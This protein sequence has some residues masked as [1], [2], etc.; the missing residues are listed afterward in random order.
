[1][2]PKRNGV[3]IPSKNVE[4]YFGTEKAIEL[5]I[6]GWEEVKKENLVIVAPETTPKKRVK[7]AEMKRGKAMKKG[8]IVTKFIE[9]IQDE[10]MLEKNLR[11]LKQGIEVRYYPHHGFSMSIRDRDYVI[12]E[13]PT[14]DDELLNIKIKDKEFTKQMVSYFNNMWRKAK[15]LD[16][17]LIEELKCQFQT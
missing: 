12:L 13:F 17:K 9:N 15:T 6:K 8:K 7:V 14:P 2:I 16:D 4:L 5:R 1:M 10:N 11:R 3:F